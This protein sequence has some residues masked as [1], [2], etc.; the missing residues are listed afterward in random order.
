MKKTR[1]INTDNA[2]S[3]LW[4]PRYGRIWYL[5]ATILVA[6]SACATPRAYAKE[7]SA[8]YKEYQIKAAFMF[9][10]L[11]F[12][13]WPETKQT[14][15]NK[16]LCVGIIGDDPFGPALDIF[17]DKKIADKDVVIKH[18]DSFKK[19]K[20]SVEED[21]AKLHEKIESL[22]KSYVVVKDENGNVVLKP[23]ESIEE[24]KNAKDETSRQ[25]L[26]EELKKKGLRFV[27]PAKEENL[28]MIINSLV[29]EQLVVLKKCH[30]L[31]VCESE[32]E[33][34]KDIAEVVKNS[35]VLT[36]SDTAGFLEAGGIINFVLEKNKIAFE[37]NLT[38]A[39]KAG[40]QIRS[41]LLRLA[42]RVVKD[43]PPANA[44]EGSPQDK[45]N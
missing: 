1:Y 34:V 4:H 10:F 44:G 26:I 24:L 23:L 38:A 37:V 20:E 39:E 32:K 33:H 27:D 15:N 11:K 40:L 5:S 21:K 19:L 13:E 22:R 14:F 17:K 45:G 16:Q 12:T 30:M 2:Q 35:G 43:E 25:K 7:Q 28:K 31:F 6:L 41:Q 9:N 8:Q 29:Q 36:I 18:F 3:R 42:K